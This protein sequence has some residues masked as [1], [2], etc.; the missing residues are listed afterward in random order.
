MNLTFA[1]SSAQLRLLAD[2]SRLRLLL[3]LEAQELTAAELTEITGLAQ[4]RIST[5][6]ARLKRA[7]LIMQR[8]SGSSALYAISDSPAVF[9]GALWQLLRERLKDR[10][11]QLDN[12]RAVQLVRA[13]SRGQTWAESV[14]GRMELQY[15]P[16]RTWETTARTLIGLLKL[17]DT[18]DIASGDGV[19]A[20]LIAAHAK[21]V[22]CVDISATLIEAAKKRLQAYQNVSFI[23]A[24][25]HNLSSVKSSC[26]DNVFMMHALAYSDKPQQAVKEAARLL[27]KGGRLVIAALNLHTHKAAMEAYDHVNLGLTPAA[28]SKLLQTA[29]LKVESCQISSREQR[30]PYFE[31]ISAIARK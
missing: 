26:Y 9:T 14:A 18:V 2:G 1:E 25:M 28:L 10:Q 23:E 15:S 4:S 11:S 30:P 22:T 27:R 24:D 7:G 20:E 8:R 29:G 19:L 31:V 21:T 6:L 12:E 16:G 13:R 5:H 17:G 3:L